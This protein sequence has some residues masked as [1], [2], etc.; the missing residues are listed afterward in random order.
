MCARMYGRKDIYRKNNWG[1]EIEPGGTIPIR[2]GRGEFLGL[3]GGIPKAGER[4]QGFARLE[5]VQSRWIEKGW[6][7]CDIIGIESFDERNTVDRDGSL[8][9]FSVPE[10][11]VVKGIGK[12][13]DLG[14]GK[15]VIHVKILTEPAAGVVKD[16]HHRMPVIRKA[17]E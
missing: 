15:K 4:I 10:G 13:E 9:E 6:K 7:P 14:G 1:R 3:W 8:V 2:T 5:T 12:V 17:N 11:A 16:V